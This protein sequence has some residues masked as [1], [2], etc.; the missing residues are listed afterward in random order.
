VFECVVRHVSSVVMWYSSRERVIS[1]KSFWKTLYKQSKQETFLFASLQAF[2]YN[3]SRCLREGSLL[4][5]PLDAI[6][7]CPRVYFTTNFDHCVFAGNLPDPQKW[8]ARSAL[9]LP[10]ASIVAAMW[11][12]VASRCEVWHGSNASGPYG[13]TLVGNVTRKHELW[14][15]EWVGSPVL[16]SFNR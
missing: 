9:W 7:I 11:E 1:F 6:V 15:L 5:N 2:G 8:G 4:R 16:M 13:S 14:F 12:V 3:T 10:L